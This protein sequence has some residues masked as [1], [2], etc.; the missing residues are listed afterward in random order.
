MGFAASIEVADLLAMSMV[1]R[2]FADFKPAIESSNG[3]SSWPSWPLDS[4]MML[5]LTPEETYNSYTVSSLTQAGPLMTR[6][7][8]PLFDAKKQS[9][10]L[11]IRSILG[12]IN[13]SLLK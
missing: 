10:S 1:E 13:L 6:I 12:S 8:T 9:S 4:I 2:G 3:V 11:S 7:M 5:L